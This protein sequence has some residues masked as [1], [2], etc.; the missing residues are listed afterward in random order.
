[1]VS[2]SDVK[3]WKSSEIDAVVND[4]LD[5]RAVAVSARDHL[6]S[7]H[8]K[9]GWEGASAEAATQSM[10]KIKDTSVRH[11]EMV[12]KLLKATQT[13][14]EGVQEVE[15][16]VQ[17][18]QEE[19]RA[20]NIDIGN[21]GKARDLCPPKPGAGMP[22]NDSG[23][24]ARSALLKA[25]EEKVHDIEHRIE[26]VCKKAEDVDNAYQQILS[27]V[28]E[29][30][31]PH[32]NGFDDA[33]FDLPDVP[34]DTSDSRKNAQWWHSLSDSEREAIRKNAVEDIKNGHGSKY[35]ALGNMDGVDAH[36]RSEINKARVD[37][38]YKRLEKEADEIKKRCY[39]P[40]LGKVSTANPDEQRV[41]ENFEQIKGVKKVIDERADVGL[42]LYDPA[43]GAPGHE[44][45]HAA[46]AVGDVD[47]ANHV[48]TYI[49][50]MT[51]NVANSGGMVDEMTNLKNR[52]EAEGAGSAAT[53]A[54]AGYDAPDDPHR[55]DRIK[56]N[57][58][59][60][61]DYS[62]TNTQ[63]A[64]AGGADLAKHL[65]G[66]EDSRNASHK[67]VHQS[68]LGHSYGS[69]TSSYGVA[70]VRPGVV[71]DYA[72]FGS[73]GVKGNA[74]TMHVPSGHNYA[75]LYKGG[76]GGAGDVIGSLK[77]IGQGAMAAGGA[78][79][80]EGQDVLGQDPVSRNSGFKAMDPGSSG[81]SSDTEAHGMYLHDGTQAQRNLAKVVV[82]KA[83]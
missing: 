83:E 61:P 30:K 74:D 43:T 77:H 3:E 80:D 22:S 7:V 37:R 49:P 27:S 79:V 68:V 31:V 50:G 29:G 9:D 70:Q 47:H 12:S 63:R 60:R 51:T 26:E 17:E 81:T 4:L 18:I 1:M 6:S 53:I 78:A 58:E 42:Y 19:A 24:T 41:L 14:Y 75:M 21:D 76:D 71:D 62:V 46:Y 65:E 10:E 2:W 82:G 33:S 13:A 73:P 36:T 32:H 67:P 48:S 72:V 52:A 69:T 66:I 34:K 45:M 8:I 40:S 59:Y 15:R 64:E 57:H 23:Y 5:E 25:R 28:Q 56:Y 11:M 35:E 54:W 38:D 16:T 44:H 20:Q 39:D 55:G